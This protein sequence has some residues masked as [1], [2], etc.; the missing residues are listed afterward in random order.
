MTPNRFFLRL[1]VLFIQVS[2]IGASEIVTVLPHIEQH[3]V[4]SVFYQNL[5]RL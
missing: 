4:I 3:A 1:P 2:P 5:L